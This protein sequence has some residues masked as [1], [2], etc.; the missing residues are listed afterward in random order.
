MRH[1]IGS[2]SRSLRLPALRLQPG[3][4]LAIAIACFSC[5]A[6][7]HH[8]F[9]RFD[10]S[11][12]YVLDGT[13]EAFEWTNPHSWIILAHGEPDGST[14]EWRLEGPSLAI[15]RK[16]GWKPTSLHIGDKLSVTLHPVRTGAHEGAFMAVKLPDGSQLTANDQVTLEQN[17]PQ[18]R[19]DL[20]PG[21]SSDSK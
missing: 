6:E 1:F 18:A 3:L 12:T 7:A 8:S 21:T 11:K 20:P 10:N 15:L 17:D 19:V 9:A 5:L 4:L 14:T 16:M 2:R 13:L